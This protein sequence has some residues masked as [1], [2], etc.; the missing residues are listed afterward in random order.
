MGNL[1]SYIE[2]KFQC[3]IN[4]YSEEELK[5]FLS[6][7][8]VDCL[9]KKGLIHFLEDNNE[10]SFEESIKDIAD[11][12]F[13]TQINEDCYINEYD[14]EYFQEKYETGKRYFNYTMDRFIREYQDA[15]NNNYQDPDYDLFPF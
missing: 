5:D 12:Y 8:K 2:D 10:T 4:N 11:D 7:M 13:Y 14:L 3:T 9:D 15:M 1:K 6:F